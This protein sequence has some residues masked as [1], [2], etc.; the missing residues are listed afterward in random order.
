MVKWM[1]PSASGGSALA[2]AATIPRMNS[3]RND[4]GTLWVYGSHVVRSQAANSS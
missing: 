2:W 3:S 4:S 1:L